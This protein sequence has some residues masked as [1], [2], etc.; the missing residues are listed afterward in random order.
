MAT[1]QEIAT[2]WRIVGSQPT[3]ALKNMIKA[4][5]MLTALNTDD[6]WERLA[7]AKIAVKYPNPRYQ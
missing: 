1:K 2:A 6:D 5:S 7:A 3:W 4:L